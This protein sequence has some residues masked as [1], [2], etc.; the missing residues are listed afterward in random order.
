[1]TFRDSQIYNII[2]Q[3]SDHFHAEDHNVIDAVQIHTYMYIHVYIPYS[4]KF[5]HGANF[6]IFRMRVLHAKIK[7][8]KIWNFCVNFDLATRGEDRDL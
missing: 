6:R 8:T 3:L 1:M 4:G 2:V 5:S 7:T